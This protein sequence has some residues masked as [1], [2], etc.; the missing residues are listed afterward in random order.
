MRS[1]G[2]LTVLGLVAAGAYLT[3]A[4]W[5]PRLMPAKTKAEW[6]P[7][8]ASG[9]ATTRRA[10]ERL[11][12]PKGPTYVE[13]SGAEF[14][15]FLMRGEPSEWADAAVIGNELHV[16]IHSE[17]I[18]VAGTID[19]PRPGVGVFRATEVAVG[20]VP[21]PRAIIFRLYHKPDS[22]TVSLPTTVGDIRV[23]HGSITLYK[24]IP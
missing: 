3:R 15:A 14:A 17:P 21:L 11:A 24:K 7:I 18:E 5:E 13:L 6:A 20:G 16:R 8:T 19:V 22:T 12:A 10:I 2:C 9:A 4:S 23:A 1:I